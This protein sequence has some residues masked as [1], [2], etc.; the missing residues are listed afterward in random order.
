M[1]RLRVRRKVEGIPALLARG[2]RKGGLH[3]VPAHADP[4]SSL[5]YFPPPPAEVCCP[6]RGLSLFSTASACARKFSR[7]S[8][9]ALVNW[10]HGQTT[11]NSSCERGDG[12]LRY[13]RT[14]E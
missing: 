2:K 12:Q 1:L 7:I 8:I 5:I 11:C 10:L 9:P 3:P 6:R 14:R 13:G 4:R